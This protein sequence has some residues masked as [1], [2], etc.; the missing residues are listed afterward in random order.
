MQIAANQL[1][2]NN[3]NRRDQAECLV[4]AEQTI[5]PPILQKRGT[6]YIITE[7][8]P[9]P[10]GKPG[11]NDLELCREAQETI[12][13][14]YYSFSAT[15][16]VTSALR[17]A[18]EKANQAIFNLNSAVLPSERRGLGVTAA[19][20]RGNEVYTA[21]MPPSQVILSHQNQLRILPEL[22]DRR[23]T[24]NPNNK[25]QRLLTLGRHGSIEPNFNR[26]VFEDGDLLILC[27]SHFVQKLTQKD[28]E[29]IVSKDNH[30][31]LVN[32]SEFARKNSLTNGYALV[33]G[34]KSDNSPQPTVASER[35]WRNAAEGVAGTVGLIA[36]KFGPKDEKEK[37]TGQIDDFAFLAQNKTE[38][39]PLAPLT[40]PKTNDASW[41]QREDDDL[42][43]PAYL[44]GRT[45]SQGTKPTVI[46]QQ[47]K[48]EQPTVVKRDFTFG[49]GATPPP[50]S[51]E[52]T[53]VTTTA[54]GSSKRPSS[55]GRVSGQPANS[56]YVDMVGDDGYGPPAKRNSFDIMALA[57]PRYLVLGGIGLVL[58]IAVIILLMSVFGGK[59]TTSSSKALELIQTAKQQLVSAQQVGDTEP[60]RARALISQA[61]TNLET[62]RKE[63][64]SLED[65]QTL[66]KDLTLALNTINRVTIPNDIR[67]A[68]D[69]S[70]QGTGV[71]LSKGLISPTADTIYL[72]DSGR[73]AVY[74]SDTA[75]TIKN[76]LKTGDKVGAATFGKPITMVSRPDGIM[77]IDEANLVWL[78]NKA[79][80]SWTSQSLGGT[81]NWAG[82]T[83]KQAG[84]FQGNL[85]LLGPGNGQ[86][87]KYNAGNYSTNPDE[88]LNPTAFSTLNLDNATGFSIDGTIYALSKEAKILQMARPSGKDK[89]ELIQ[90]FDPK[91]TNSLF[92][93]L[94]SPTALNVGSLDFPQIF[95]L[96]SEKRVV[97]FRKE[98]GAFIQQ[99]QAAIDHKEF[100]NL[101]D[102]MI[103]EAA[104]KVYIVGL[105]KVHVFALSANKPVLTTS[106][107]PSN[108]QQ[109]GGSVNVTVIVSNPTVKP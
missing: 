17:H 39:D 91:A 20:V 58:F 48:D 51:E 34:A 78:Y 21:Q 38:V 83:I 63:K 106:A 47:N 69:V 30:T 1:E 54:W 19:L 67:M 71:R 29:T 6:L 5:A 107:T 70:S 99:F 56:P 105:Q 45:I 41:L 55:S 36:S 94:S 37:G 12:L 32:L 100:D 72:L 26:N 73:G 4:D 98:D 57:N 66:Q 59:S 90:E 25:H 104:K 93:P 95:V 64:A 76:I 14:E 97:Q 80:G 44:R 81:A 79:A 33:A 60:S 22:P 85:Y 49:G 68:I 82:K 77:V 23:A 11:P 10:T 101:Q 2:L 42:N 61:Q 92:P 28:L 31:T 89:G 16:T 75:G 109:P 86:I 7:A 18:L 108:S 3:G 35:T 52:T 88:W 62:A 27:S 53:E 84:S 65:T 40:K 8:E 9:L 43:R 50:S 102:I 13:R 24:Q 87:L 96:D 46:K 74:Q 15:A 103:D